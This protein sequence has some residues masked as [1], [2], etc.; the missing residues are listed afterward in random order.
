MAICNQ[1]KVTDTVVA[2]YV[3][4]LNATNIRRSWSRENVRNV[5]VARGASTNTDEDSIQ[6]VASDTRYDSPTRVNGPFGTSTE[7]IESPAFTTVSNALYGAKQRLA[8]R[9][10]R[11]TSVE[12]EAVYDPRLEP[13]DTVEVVLRT[14]EVLKRTVRTITLPLV[15]SATMTMTLYDVTEIEGDGATRTFDKNYDREEPPIVPF[16]EG[17]PLEPPVWSPGAPD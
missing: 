16:V 2:R 4:D 1:P 15:P 5:I 11:R 6:A 17:P 13:G 12:I 14:G 3:A 9:L 8:R 7:I 10:T